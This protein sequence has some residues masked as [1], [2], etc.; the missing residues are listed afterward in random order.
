MECRHYLLCHFRKNVSMQWYSLNILKLIVLVSAWVGALW[1]YLSNYIP[2]DDK[3]S[4]IYHDLH[5]LRDLWSSNF[6]ISLQRWQVHGNSILYQTTNNRAHVAAGRRTWLLIGRHAGHVASHWSTPP[7]G[8]W[9]G[10]L[11]ARWIRDKIISIIIISDEIVFQEPVFPRGPWSGLGT[12]DLAR[13]AAAGGARARRHQCNRTAVFRHLFRK[14]TSFHIITH[15]I[16]LD[17]L[18]MF[19]YQMSETTQVCIL[20]HTF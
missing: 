10:P 18:P 6:R 3:H 8:H 15:F 16:V 1:Y 13:F 9:M 2:T 17:Y 12:A 11:A 5:C 19:A 14:L 20:L 7:P 4:I